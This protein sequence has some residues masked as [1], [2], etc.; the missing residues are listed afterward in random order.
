MSALLAGAGSAADPR[1]SAGGRTL[2]G[3]FTHYLLTGLG[4]RADRDADGTVDAAELVGYVTAGVRDAT[5]GGQAPVALGA[6]GRGLDLARARTAPGEA[7]T[8][9]A[10]AR[11]S[12]GPDPMQ[13]ANAPPPQPSA[14]GGTGAA[15]TPVASDGRLRTMD[16]YMRL[17]DLNCLPRITEVEVP[18]ERDVGGLTL[19][20]R[21][22]RAEVVK[23][24]ADARVVLG[25]LGAIKD[26][27][28]GTYRNLETALAWF[29]ES[30]VEAVVVNGDTG[31]DEMEIRESLEI[32]GQGGLP[33][34]VTIGNSETVGALHGALETLGQ[35]YANLVNM[36]LVRYVDLDDAVLISLPGY[37]NKAFIHA[38]GGCEYRDKH[39]EEV[40][41]LAKEARAPVVLVS[42]GPPKGSGKDALD[43]ATDAGNVGDP[44]LGDLMRR[45][46]IH[47]GV[48]GHILE[49]GGAAR[50]LG[51]RPVAPDTATES[52]QLNVGQVSS[53]PWLLNSGTT[54]RGVAAILTIDGGRA[55]YRFRTLTAPE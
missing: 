48:F 26:A 37:F 25:L 27:E 18:S 2:G 28:P 21:G 15:A 46:G 54:T 10:P 12:A 6:S 5:G 22:T 24:D 1:W 17:N 13:V 16:D 53:M 42:H 43:H 31:Y 20:L 51:D 44:R 55:R 33:V 41:T 14:T 4:G 3:A 35:Q 36:D 47:F 49:A 50:D 38:T 30:G 34:F 32:L 8:A 9:A 45:A 52:L 11:A 39:I 40:A 7:T 23:R 19:R 29:R